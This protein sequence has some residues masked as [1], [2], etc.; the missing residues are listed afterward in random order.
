[1]SLIFGFDI[2]TTSIGFAVID[3]DPDRKTG[4]IHRLGVRVFPEARDPKGVPLN[5]ERR[6]ARM[7][8]RQYRRR[9]ARRRQLYDDLYQAGLL[10]SRESE[11]DWNEAMKWDPYELRKRAYD[12]HKCESDGKNLSRHEI[13]RAIYHLAQRRHFKGRDIDEISDAV[14][15]GNDRLD[16]ADNED[17]KNVA[18][19]RKETVRTLKQEGKTLGAWLSER[20]PHERRRGVHATRALVQDEFDEIWEPL[21]PEDCREIIRDTIFSQRPVFWRWNTL[22][23]CPF[24]PDAPPCPSGAWLSQQKR[25]LEKLNNISLVGGNQRPLDEE[26]RQAILAKLQTQASMTWPS[27]RGALGPLYR[28]RGDAGLE[29]SLKFNLEE[30]GQKKLLGNAVEAKLARIFGDDWSDHPSKQAIRDTVPIRLWN[31][32]Y[33]RIGAQRVA[34]RS[35][36]ERQSLREQAKRSFVE[37]LGITEDRAV[38]LAGLKLPAGWEPFSV[39][40]LEAFLPHLEAGERFGELLNGPEWKAWRSATFPNREQTTGEAFGR[41]PSPADPEENK[42]IAT[43]RNPTVARTRNELRKVVNNLIDMFGKPDLIRVELARDVGISKRERESR[44]QGIR[45]QEG[46]RTQARNFLINRGIASPS[47][48]DVEK[49]MLW[50]ESHHRCPYTGDSISFDAL[51]KTG[52]F[53]VEHIWPRSRCLDDSFR[54]KTL[55]R[56]DV[57]LAKGNKIP[58]EYFGHNCSTWKAIENRLYGMKASKSSIGISQGK[59]NRFLANA[60][61]TDFANRQLNDTGWAARNAIDYL[62]KLWPDRGR[63]AP[64]KV[65]AV[66]GRVTAHLRRLWGLNNILA[67]DGEKTR[68]NHCHHAIDALVVACCHPGMTQKLSHYWQEKENPQ[69]AKPNLPPPWKAIRDGA[70]R[71]VDKIVVSHRVRK[72]ISG[73]LHKDTVYGDT[74]DEELSKRGETYRF[75]V[76]RKNVEDLSK[77]QIDDIRDDAVRNIIMSWVERHGGNP[78]KAF[79]PYP[80]RGRKGP[81]IRRVRLLKKQQVEL[82]APVSTGYADL[83]KNHHISIYRA[84]DGSVDYEVVSLFEAS[85]RLTRH[86]SVVRRKG[87]NGA[88]FVMSLSPGD[89]LE[90]SRNGRTETWIVREVRSKGQIYLDSHDDAV[91]E[92]RF[93]PRVR[94]LIDRYGA[95]KISIDPVGRIRP[96]ND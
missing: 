57:N 85:R 41:L 10:P 49:F 12:L 15:D 38:L 61:P 42:R 4:K 31:A 34:I 66:S 20:G 43:L 40:A 1:M 27:V 29:K 86:E 37:D 91:G 22:R 44:T 19:K 23:K 77:T 72:K 39:K 80:K 33:K 7:R 50:E 11:E 65:H 74:G 48:S 46:R 2:G 18:A 59:I 92:T 87:R 26:E 3:H 13:G 54:N 6:Q 88:K 45:R 53:E 67:D 24:I 81:E 52:E 17:E 5:Q 90:L 8:R 16:A 84:T 68:A 70:E 56:R 82:M 96:A 51:F 25:M 73:P 14:D 21:L 79:P 60:I 55:C 63:D 36:T 75:F 62:K 9:R 76:V 32:D 94:P 35:S 58:F 93:G 83:G 30:G 64:V 89:A 78:K 69:I 95:K 47:R 71:A 28:A